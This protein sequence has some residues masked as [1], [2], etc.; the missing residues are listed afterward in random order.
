MSFL[1]S[2]QNNSVHSSY[3]FNHWELTEPLTNEQIKE[4]EKKQKYAYTQDE[5][6]KYQE[7]KDKI[8][9][10]AKIKLSNYIINKIQC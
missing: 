6:Q 2:F 1:K 3:P 7:T 10:E 8:G 9:W 4:I 5:K